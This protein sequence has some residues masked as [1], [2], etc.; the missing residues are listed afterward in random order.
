MALVA[1][2]AERIGTSAA[3]LV[4]RP[5]CGQMGTADVVLSAFAGLAVGVSV[6]MTPRGAQRACGQGGRIGVFYRGSDARKVEEFRCLNRR[7]GQSAAGGG[8][9]AS[10]AVD[11]DVVMWAGVA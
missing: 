10:P 8:L 7:G 5:I 9:L 11:S 6:A 1:A 2:V 3:P 4:Y